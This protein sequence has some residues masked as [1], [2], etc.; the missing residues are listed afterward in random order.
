MRLHL[1]IALGLL[2]AGCG[3]P[4][5]DP[6][7]AAPAADAWSESQLALL[8]SLSIASLP[9]PPP[10]PSSRVADDPAAA[11]L[12]H[13]L[14]FDPG[15]SGNG[16]VSCA[17]CHLPELLFTD[18]RATSRGIGDTARNAPTL[19]G[20]AHSPWMFWDGRRDSLWA[21]A[22]APLETLAEMGGT[23][24]G[25]VRHVA[26]EPALAALYA[27]AF[28][29]APAATDG[30]P[31]RAGPFGSPEEQAAW[32]RIPAADRRSID[33]AFANVGK[34]IAAYERLLQPG[35]S[36]FDR[37]VEDLRSG[38][39]GAGAALSAEEIRGL[40]L[41]ADAGRT[42]CLRC[43]N[44]PL[45]T[46]QSFHDVG[47]GAGAGGL[48]DFG[49]FLGIQAALID[50]F[51][52]LGEFS[53]AR[54]E[55]CGELRFLDTAHVEGGIGRFK[56][57]TLRGLPRTGPY[58]HDGRFATLRAVV[59]HYRSPPPGG[60]SPEITPLEIDDAES[61][62]LVAFLGSLDGGTQAPERW[63]RPPPAVAARQPQGPP[64]PS[65]GGR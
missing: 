4:S 45:L 17:T 33:R 62:A 24:L 9:P 56:T 21:Q 35:P 51:N 19:V 20:A 32:Q 39:S 1:A 29:E 36:R 41:F 63:L 10:D 46:N 58:M 27:T 59:E 25:V 60:A 30:H 54:P 7:G 34:A 40:R 43:H 49:R 12:G 14:F 61:L 44:G 28:G 3:E 26:R 52:C 55:Q 15:L 57:P 16:S 5:P 37:Y 64:P 2:A 42:L 23:R 18:G 13:R 11:E 53:D 22:L 48:P 65:P 38:G 47:T 31:E 8:E 50:P 6:G